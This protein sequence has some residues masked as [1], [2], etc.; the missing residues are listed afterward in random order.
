[1][2]LVVGGAGQGKLAWTLQQSGLKIKDV[3]SRP[4]DAA[5]ILTELEE[6]VRKRLAAGE[7]PRELLPTL[8]KKKYILCREVGC[9]V[10]PLDP[11]D[12][13]WREETGRLCCTLALEATGVVRLCCGI[14]QVLKALPETE[15]GQP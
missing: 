7:D 13:C 3:S 2:I 12:R 10:V 4:E 1:V 6:L 5:P 11:A 9:G 14:P 15:G 8:R